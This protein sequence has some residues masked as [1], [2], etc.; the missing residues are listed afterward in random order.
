[1]EYRWL[2][3]ESKDDTKQ[4]ALLGVYRHIAGH[5][6]VRAGYN[7]TDF[8]DNLSDRDYDSNGWFMDFVGK[9]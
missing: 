4:G 3:S 1:M 6:K 5:F 7:F 8:R 9:Y 2:E